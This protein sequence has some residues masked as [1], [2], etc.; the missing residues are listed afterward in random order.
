MCVCV[1]VYACVCVRM[2]MC[3]CVYMCYVYACLYACFCACM[4]VCVCMCLY[5][6]VY[7]R[8]CAQVMATTMATLEALHL[9]LSA[10]RARGNAYLQIRTFQ[11]VQLLMALPPATT[12]GSR[13]QGQVFACA[14]PVECPFLLLAVIPIR[15]LRPSA[16]LCDATRA[17]PRRRWGTDRAQQPCCNVHSLTRD[18]LP[19]QW[20]QKLAGDE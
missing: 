8:V 20:E 9:Y 19:S 3:A 16:L 11:L 13:D 14:R 17:S 18:H 10:R 6:C 12:V 5:P 15:C 2:C 1:C 4:Y 7:A